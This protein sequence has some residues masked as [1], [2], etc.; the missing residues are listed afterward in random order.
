MHAQENEETMHVRSSSAGPRTDR[1]ALRKGLRGSLLAVPVAMGGLALL[2]ACGPYGGTQTAASAAPA[3]GG[4]VVA[5][6]STDLGRILVD[7]HGRTVYDFANDTAGVSTCDGA[8]AQEWMPVAAPDTLPASLP[9][10]P[11]VLGST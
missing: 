2:A 9:G 3:A 4:A 11:A 7:S 10:V 1:P 8:C 5:T 6:A